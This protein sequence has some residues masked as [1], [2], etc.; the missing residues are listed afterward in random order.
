M[1][2][3]TLNSLPGNLPMATSSR[4]GSMNGTIVNTMYGQSLDE[5]LEH[6][7]IRSIDDLNEETVAYLTYVLEGR[8]P[9]TQFQVSIDEYYVWRA[10]NITV[11]DVEYDATSQHI[12]IK[13]T[14]TGLHE[15]TLSVFED[16][17]G[18][19]AAEINDVEDTDVFH[20]FTCTSADIRGPYEVS[21]KQADVGLWKVGDQRPLVVVEVGVNESLRE[22]RLR[23]FDGTSGETTTVILVNITEENRPGP[24]PAHQT[25]GLTPFELHSIDHRRLAHRIYDWHKT[26]CMPLVGDQIKYDVS[27]LRPGPRICNAAV[28]VNVPNADRD[29]APRYRMVQDITVILGDSGPDYQD[30]ESPRAGLNIRHLTCNLGKAVAKSLPKERASK[31]AW[32]FVA[33]RDSS[34]F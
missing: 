3:N 23:W 26:H 8:V 17:L 27:V 32:A 7:N 34:R 13:A 33:K 12:V 25:W 1:A 9:L 14:C 29:L 31:M 18:E 16:W 11:R 10:Q 15:T 30:P 21:E 19:W 28:N 4:R 24:P 2:Q 22:D 5:I 20:C 6:A